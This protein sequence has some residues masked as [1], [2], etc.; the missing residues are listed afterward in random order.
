MIISEEITIN[1]PLPV[2]WGVFERMEDWQEWN[3]VC[4]NC[5][6]LEGEKMTTGTCFS[7]EMTPYF[8]PIK[9]VPRIVKCEPGREVIWEGRRFGIHAVH[10]F[11]FTED[12]DRVRL[13][14]VEEFRGPLVGLVRL[15]MVP[16]RLHHL[17][18]QLMHSIKLKSESCAA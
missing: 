13:L 3:T 17:T 5:C 12:G 7:F 10:R 9:V 16:R 8:F 4:A 15:L 11:T 6:I 2:V 18:R 14:S 1:A